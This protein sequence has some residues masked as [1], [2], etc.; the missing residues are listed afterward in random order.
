MLHYWTFFPGL[1]PRTEIPPPDLQ[2]ARLGGIMHEGDHVQHVL[3]P[4][5]HLQL[6]VAIF[7]LNLVFRVRRRRVDH[8]S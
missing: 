3:E 8:L 7:G 6:V 5:G 4:S 2:A 1:L